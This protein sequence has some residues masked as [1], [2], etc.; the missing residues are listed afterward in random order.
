MVILVFFDLTENEINA[1]DG[2]DPVAFN[3]QY[4]LT[5]TWSYR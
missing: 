3:V 5:E 1:L 2:N 4:F